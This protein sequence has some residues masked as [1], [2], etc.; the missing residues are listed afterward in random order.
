MKVTR[1]DGLTLV[2]ILIAMLVFAIGALGL[3]ASSAS[4]A[5]QMSWNADRSRASTLARTRIEKTTASRC[6]SASG[7]DRSGT[8]MSDWIAADEG[9]DVTLQ[10]TVIRLDSRAPHVDVFRAASSCR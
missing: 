1:R 10:Q 3:A 2:E 6:A 8:V 4:L 5:R 7:S 9:S